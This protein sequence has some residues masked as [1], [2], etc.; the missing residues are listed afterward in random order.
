M[1]KRSETNCK[2]ELKMEEHQSF[3]KAANW[4]KGQRETAHTTHKVLEP[5]PGLKFVYFSFF[6]VRKNLIV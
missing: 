3:L 6:F 5:T 4:A 2:A 1:G